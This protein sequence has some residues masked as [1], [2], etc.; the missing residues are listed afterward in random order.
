MSKPAP[1]WFRKL[2]SAVL[3][4]VIAA[5]AMMAQWGISDELLITRIQLWLTIGVG[6]IFEA[7]EK[8]LANGEEY[9]KADK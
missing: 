5:N 7:L 1:K 3:V 9:A 2:K 6:A 8:L 4:L